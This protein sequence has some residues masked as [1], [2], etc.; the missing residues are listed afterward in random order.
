MHKTESDVPKDIQNA[1]TSLFSIIPLVPNTHTT[2]SPDKSHSYKPE[3]FN[4]NEW[5]LLKAACDQL[6]AKAFLDAT[7]TLGDL[8]AFIDQ[9]MLSPYA[10]GDLDC[11]QDPFSDTPVKLPQGRQ[12]LR[13]LVRNGLADLNRYS[14]QTHQQPFVALAT[15]EQQQ[16]LANA[17]AGLLGATAQEFLSLLRTEI[18]HSR[19]AHSL[20]PAYEPLTA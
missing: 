2:A 9:H 11:L 17:E 3:F 20:F 15:A 1:P 12:P 13:D 8:P 14:Q 5:A 4:E 10:H 18:E 6:T 7:E 19:F 16:V